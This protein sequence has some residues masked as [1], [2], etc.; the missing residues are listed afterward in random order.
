MGVR[1][2]FD[3]DDQIVVDDGGL[4]W[5]PYGPEPLAWSEI[6]RIEARS[7]KRQR[8]LCIFLKDPSRRPAT[9]WTGALLAANSGFGFGDL[10]LS[11]TGTD[12]SHGELVEAVRRH[13]SPALADF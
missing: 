5:K 4:F 2:L 7:I 10:A 8:F 13:A 12:R 6:D 9:G 1:R 11:T 3:R